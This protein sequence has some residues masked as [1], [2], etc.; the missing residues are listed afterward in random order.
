ME[1]LLLLTVSRRIIPK[2]LHTRWSVLQLILDGT[3][4]LKGQ[5]KKSFLIRFTKFKKSFLLLS[6]FLE[7]LEIERDDA[8]VSFDPLSLRAILYGFTCV[9]VGVWVVQKGERR[10]YP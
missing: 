3:K 6:S 7:W 9:C 1:H 2:L 5:E 4:S 10:F 8:S